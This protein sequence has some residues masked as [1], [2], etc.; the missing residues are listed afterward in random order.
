MCGSTAALPHDFYAIG[1]QVAEAEGSFRALNAADRGAAKPYV[2][3]T[4]SF[5]R[6]GFAE[7]AKSSPLMTRPEAQ[8]RLINGAFGGGAEP[9]AGR[10]VKVVKVVG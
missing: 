2:V 3:K 1:A 10:V 8:L 5:P 4:V 9:K 6:G 7:L